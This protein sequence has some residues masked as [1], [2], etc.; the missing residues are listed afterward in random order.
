MS[1]GTFR[2]VLPIPSPYAHHVRSPVLIT[3]RSEVITIETFLLCRTNVLVSAMTTQKHNTVRTS[4]TTFE[5]IES[6]QALDGAGV[7]EV[8][9]RIGVSKSTVYKHLNSLVENGYVI[10]EGDVYRIG[11]RFLDLGEHARHRSLLYKLARSEIEELANAVNEMANLMVEE[12]GE[13]VF[14]FRAD[15]DRAVN[16]D[17]RAGKRMQLH[18]TALG[19]AIMAHLPEE[20]LEWIIDTYGLSRVT[21]NTIT[22]EATLREELHRIR[23]RGV[24]FDD[25]ERIAG[26]RCV[27][28]PIV[29]TE[30]EVLGAISASGPTSRIRG[31]RFREEIPEHV[32]RTKNIIELNVEYH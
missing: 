23:E 12:N 19:K 13:G 8:A 2:P 31:D 30:D 16:L 5:V 7:T 32:L 22:D 25:E 24:A 17:T 28:A 29:T 21:E 27:A 6:L 4:Q 26:L 18:T 9:N 10:K 11:L 20:R 3:R 15:S 1:D 14:L